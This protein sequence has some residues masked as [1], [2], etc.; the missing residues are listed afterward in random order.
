MDNSLKNIIKEIAQNL[1]CGYNCYYNSKTNEIL[2]IP[3]FDNASDEQEVKE[4]FRDDLNKIDEQ[5][6][7]FIKF[8]VLESFESFKIMQRFSEQMSDQNFKSKL[9]SI[10]ENKKPFQNFNKTID[11]SD[12]RQEWFDFKENELEKIVETQ[13]NRGKA[14]AQQNL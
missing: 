12:F 8:E 5:K 2:T 14:S 4:H 3:N 9:K 1:D 6:S 7:D 10:L 11:N 13:L